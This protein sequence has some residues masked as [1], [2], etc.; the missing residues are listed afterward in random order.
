MLVDARRRLEHHNLPLGD[1]YNISNVIFYL[2]FSGPSDK[3]L[4]GVHTIIKHSETDL[5]C[6]QSDIFLSPNMSSAIKLGITDKYYI[7]ISQIYSSIMRKNCMKYVFI[8]CEKKIS[9]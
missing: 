6:Q 2:C 8:S 4:Y 3:G 5:E 9:V 7:K 1:F